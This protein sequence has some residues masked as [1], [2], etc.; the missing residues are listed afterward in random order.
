MNITSGVQ[1]SG[2]E[3]EAVALLQGF[4]WS[5]NLDQFKRILTSAFHHSEPPYIK[6]PTVSEIL[7]KEAVAYSA[8]VSEDL[9]NQG[10]SLK[11]IE[12][13][14]VMNTLEKENFNQSSTARKLKISRTTLWR[15]INR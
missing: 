2:M 15:I 11:E 5:H 14:I 8:P 7:R 10:L 1:I 6:A 3:P 9:L 4:R 13:S 12:Y